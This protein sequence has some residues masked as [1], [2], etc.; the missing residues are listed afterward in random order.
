MLRQLL[1]WLLCNDLFYGFK[2]MILLHQQCTKNCILLFYTNHKR[3]GKSKARCERIEKEYFKT[4]LVLKVLMWPINKTM[5]K[6]A[7]F[8]AM[9]H[10]LISKAP[11]A[12]F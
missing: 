2:K 4:I 1:Y 10:Y 11:Q 7:F 3:Q 6:I 9:F 5:P 12:K 8:K